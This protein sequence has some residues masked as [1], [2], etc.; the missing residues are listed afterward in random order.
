[1]LIFQ[2]MT[3]EF[4][5]ISQSESN[6]EAAL[7]FISDIVFQSRSSCCLLSDNRSIFDTLKFLTNILIFNPRN[8]MRFVFFLCSRLISGNLKTLGQ[9]VNQEKSSSSY[10]FS[11]IGFISL[12]SSK[13]TV[14]IF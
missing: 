2:S 7:K 3:L 1:M 9:G 12:A 13:P 14:R 11:F 5:S 8:I 6:P 10:Y 4:H